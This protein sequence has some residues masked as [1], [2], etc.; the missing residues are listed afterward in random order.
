M[1]KLFQVFAVIGVLGVLLAVLGRFIGNNTVSLFNIFSPMKAVTVLTIAN[2]FL[3][4]SVMA[5]L[6]KKE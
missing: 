6:F 4:L 2:T 3:L 1:K 5:F